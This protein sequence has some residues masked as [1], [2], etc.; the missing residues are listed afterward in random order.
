MNVHRL[1]PR[2][3]SSESEQDKIWLDASLLPDDRIRQQRGIAS[4]PDDPGLLAEIR[5]LSGQKL[6]HRADCAP[7]DPGLDR[8]P[9]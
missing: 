4:G 6:S 8:R 3:S 2:E 9:R 7:E 5:C 1:V